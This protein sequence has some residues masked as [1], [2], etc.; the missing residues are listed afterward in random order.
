MRQKSVT[1]VV[2][3][4]T[5][6]TADDL[7]SFADYLASL[8]IHGCDVIVLDASPRDVFDENARMLRWVSRHV[9]VRAPFDIV[10]AAADLAATEKIIVARDD[11][12]YEPAN[13]HD[14]CA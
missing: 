5:P 13:V 3:I 1:Y 6:E 14:V 11:V 7:R 8:G 9:A 12:R 4:E 2:A 10:R